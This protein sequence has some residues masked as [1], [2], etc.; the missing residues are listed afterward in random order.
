MYPNKGKQDVSVF[1]PTLNCRSTYL[2]LRP[3][4]KINVHLSVQEEISGGSAPYYSM[5]YIGHIIHTPGFPKYLS[6]FRAYYV[7]P[8]DRLIGLVV[9]MPDY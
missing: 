7:Y 3:V 5:D 8:T 2:I 4:A 6:I 1:H 9:S